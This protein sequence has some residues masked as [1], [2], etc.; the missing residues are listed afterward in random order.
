MLDDYAE[1]I[2][3]HIVYVAE[4]NRAVI[5]VIVLIQQESTMLLDNVAVH[6]THQ[7]KGIGSRLLKHAETETMRRGYRTLTLYTHECMTENIAMYQRTG[8]V[9]TTRKSEHGYARVYME[10]VLA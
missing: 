5:G 3:K 7:G 1:V 10:K 9:E 8:Y 6:P 4:M 2:R